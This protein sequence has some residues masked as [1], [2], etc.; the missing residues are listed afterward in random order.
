MKGKV[1]LIFAAHTTVAGQSGKCSYMKKYLALLLIPILLFGCSSTR[2]GYH[3]ADRFIQWGMN[4]YVSLS[5]EQRDW[6]EGKVDEL[7][8]WHR[9]EQ[10]PSYIRFVEQVRSDVQRDLTVELLNRRNESLQN[11]FRD[12]MV[13]IEPDFEHLL[14]WLNDEQKRQFL[15]VIVNEQKKLEEGVRKSTPEKRNREQVEQTIR[16]FQWFVGK[17]TPDQKLEIERWVNKRKPVDE[18]WLESRREWINH[19]E[20][21][22][23]G[24][25]ADADLNQ[26]ADIGT[27]FSQPKQLPDLN[28]L[29]VY[30]ESLWSA[31]YRE[32]L[33]HNR[34]LTLEL[35]VD[36]HG[37][38]TAKQLNHL[39]N[40]LEKVQSDLV[41]LWKKEPKI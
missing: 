39:I 19:F 25:K 41:Y 3:F 15:Q 10:L 6:F 37:R 9:R 20:S 17:L 34:K 21:L 7:M 14:S 35:I 33:D 24:K 32:V 12:I 18:L 29:I 27:N 13:K 30:P 36:I 5:D 26:P 31:Q 11:F 38:L 8:T 23:L 4:H 28:T 22:L 16:I 2:I 1:F 40:Y